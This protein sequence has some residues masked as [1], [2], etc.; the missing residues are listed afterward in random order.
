MNIN[1][2]IIIQISY[3]MDQ[4]QITEAKSI[5][6]NVTCRFTPDMNS[7]IYFKRK[8][9]LHG[10]FYHNKIYTVIITIFPR[11]VK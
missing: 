3:Y 10:K 11:F 1:T 7:L 8:Y 9:L 5:R 4:V 2:K 6:Q